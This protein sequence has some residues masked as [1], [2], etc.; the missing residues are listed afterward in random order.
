MN[1]SSCFVSACLSNR[2]LPRPQQPIR[3]LKVHC[4][5]LIFYTCTKTL[6][7][8][9]VCLLHIIY[10]RLQPLRIMFEN[11]TE[12]PSPQQQLSNKLVF[13]S[14]IFKLSFFCLLLL[15]F[16]WLIPA[17]EPIGIFINCTFLKKKKSFGGER[18]CQLCAV[19]E[20]IA[21]FSHFEYVERTKK[22]EDRKRFGLKSGTVV[23]GNSRFFFLFLSTV[24]H[25]TV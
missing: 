9:I 14:Y 8:Y 18:L 2:F 10:I 4:T 1:S 19:K 23:I 11:V 24:Q 5:S 20:F 15:K 13:S 12:L 7:C 21:H 22:K 3:A 6:C 25:D 17:A 16:M